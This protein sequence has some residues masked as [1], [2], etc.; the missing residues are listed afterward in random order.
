M[1]NKNVKVVFEGNIFQVIQETKK[2][3]E[4]TI[5]MEY[6]KRAPGVRVIVV[7]DNKILLNEEIRHHPEGLD[8]RIPGGKVYDSL[9][10][11]KKA[12]DDKVDLKKAAEIAGIREIEEETGHHVKNLKFHHI[13]QGGASIHFELYFF[14]TSDCNKTVQK[15]EP[16]EQIKPVWKSYDEVKEMC[17]KKEIKE[18][19]SAAVLL[20]FLKDK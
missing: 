11:F 1:K 8:Y 3:G 7:K 18:D 15:L 6:V 20:R 12:L 17:Y 16:G 19:I 10:D 5:N 13:S 14:T 2:H 4:H 9:I